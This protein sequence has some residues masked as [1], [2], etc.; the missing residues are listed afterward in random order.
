[1]LAYIN[2]TKYTHVIQNNRSIEAK[3]FLFLLIFYHQSLVYIS[4]LV[5]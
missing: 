4:F 3:T 2:K 1:M 5:S